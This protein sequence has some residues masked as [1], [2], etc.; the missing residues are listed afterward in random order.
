MDNLISPRLR[1][2]W[3]DT[4]RGRRERRRDEQDTAGTRTSSWRRHSPGPRHGQP[5]P[6]R[7]PD[8]GPGNKISESKLNTFWI[9]VDLKC[10]VF[11]R[12]FEQSLMN[13]R[14]LH[15]LVDLHVFE[16]RVE[17]HRGYLGEDG[18]DG[19]VRC[20]LQNRQ[21]HTNSFNFNLTKVTN[22]YEL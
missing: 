9:L 22:E 17:R 12:E 16:G 19:E 15:H 5:R 8:S 3:I 21:N 13:L 1:C 2:W 14:Y 10:V 11:E 18:L 7:R 4:N 6:S 20:K